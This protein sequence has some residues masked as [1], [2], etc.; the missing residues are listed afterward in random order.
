MARVMH[1]DV[2]VRDVQRAI[3]FYE[4]AFEWKAEKWDG[5][6]EYWMVTTG[7]SDREGI[8][9]GLSQGEPNLTSGQLTLDVESL[10]E[11]ISRVTAAGGS[12]VR[13]RS[14]VP[15]VG[16][17]AEVSDTEGNR[18]GLMQLDTTAGT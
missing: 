12:V 5:P 9:G 16:Y 1:F 7:P 8:D 17:L 11:T 18:F 14:P 6:M 15:G 10:D 2:V 4:A 13:E 3:R